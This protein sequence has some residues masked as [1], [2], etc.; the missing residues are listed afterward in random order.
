[1]SHAGQGGVHG[2]HDALYLGPYALS[3]RQGSKHPPRH[4]SL[5]AGFWAKTLMVIARRKTVKNNN[6]ECWVDIYH[7]IAAEQDPRRFTQLI[8]ELIRVLDETNLQPR[9]NANKTLG[10][11]DDIR[12]GTS[13]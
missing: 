4:S 11:T 5:Q 2:Q 1:M 6:E 13:H 7:R 8:Q 3:P 9:E 10:R 12:N